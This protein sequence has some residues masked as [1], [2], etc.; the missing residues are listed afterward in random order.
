MI[1]GKR[2]KDMKKGINGIWKTV[3]WILAGTLLLASLGAFAGNVGTGICWI[4]AALLVCPLSRGALV[5]ALSGG[6]G[7]RGQPGLPGQNPLSRKS[8]GT[9]SNI[10]LGVLAAV[11]L[12]IGSNAYTESR[13]DSLPDALHESS[14]EGGL[15]ENGLAEIGLSESGQES[16]V[17]D[18][19]SEPLSESCEA[20]DLASDTVSEAIEEEPS[21]SDME[22]HFLDVGQGDA[23]L[24]KADGHYMLIDAGDNSKGTTVQ[25]YLTK[26]GVEKL[27]YLILTHT[28]ADHIGGADVIITKFDIDHIFLGDFKKEN[29]TYEEL[30]D[31]MEY[32]SMQYETPEVGTEYQLG[33]ASF[34]ILAP[35]GTYED[36]NNGSIALVLKNGENKFLFSG[37]CEAEAEAA[38]LSNGLDIDVDVYKV[39]HHGSSTSSTQAFLDAMTPTYAVISCEENNSYGHPHAETLNHLR[40]MDVKVFRTDE[41]G[42]I[43][44][45]SNGTE[46]TWNCAPSDSWKAGE[47]TQ[48]STQE[49]LSAGENGPTDGTTVDAAANSEDKAVEVTSDSNNG[50]A[51]ESSASS[52]ESQREESSEVTNTG[53]YAVNANNGKIHMV[54]GCSATGSGKNAMKNPVYFNTYEEAEAYSIQIAP[55]LEKRKCG[56]CW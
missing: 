45:Y 3:Q 12:G 13:V 22:V 25:L 11:F 6:K 54:G 23:T 32:R 21:F 43:I 9:V 1:V 28:D 14:A 17:E 5:K 50:A 24:I 42:T 19:N 27:D 20:S 48:N 56:N 7:K 40:A 41:Q 53:S 34:T 47:Q 55:G 35:N 10:L 33:N 51:P 16:T 18:Q 52:A 44:A 30:M 2:G 31:A 46:I 49:N 15:A 38:I 36:P 4:L 37:D 8:M 39:G 26:Q 29:T